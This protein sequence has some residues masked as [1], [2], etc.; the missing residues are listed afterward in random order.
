MQNFG[1]FYIILKIKI[2]N[3][4]NINFIN[5]VNKI[6]IKNNKNFKLLKTEKFRNF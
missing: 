6:L 3:F 1:R 4:I 2:I 5:S